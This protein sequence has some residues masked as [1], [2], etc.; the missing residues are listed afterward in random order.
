MVNGKPKQGCF[1]YIINPCLR[2]CRP[3]LLS[4]VPF[5]SPDLAW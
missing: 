3:G 5:K 1:G 4:G 2:P